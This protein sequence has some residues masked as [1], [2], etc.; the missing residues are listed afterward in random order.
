M[1]KDLRYEKAHQAIK[2]AFWILMKEE[3][4]QKITVTSIIK[5]ANINR[6]TFYA[7]YL[8]KYDLL[9]QL[10]DELFEGIFLLV[11]E[12]VP[13]IIHSKKRTPE[14]FS[15]YFESFLVYMKNNGEDFLLLFSPNGD[16]FFSQRFHQAVNDFWNTYH[17]KLSPSLPNKYAQTAI[18]GMITNLLSE[19]VASGFEE[20]P[21]EF[22]KIV[23]TLLAPFYQQI[24]T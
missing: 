12:N 9:N 14:V 2:Q 17:L 19:W 21:K 13:S 3:G 11:Y 18:L 4:F 1:K 24:L 7:H 10:E 23:M 5:L 20:S 15:M 8:D 16:P 6:S 22:S